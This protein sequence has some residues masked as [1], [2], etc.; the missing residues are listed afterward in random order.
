VSGPRSTCKRCGGPKP[1]GRG[2]QVCDACAASPPPPPNPN[3]H[4]CGGPKPPGRGRRLCAPCQLESEREIAPDPCL[5]CGGP[6]PPGSA[7]RLC[8]DCVELARWKKNAKKRS[9][10]QPCIDCGRPKG[11]GHRR[12]LCDPCRAKREREHGR[13]CIACGERKVRYPR[14]QLCT[15]CKL[16]SEERRRE[17][18][19]ERNRRYRAEG[20]FQGRGTKDLENHRMAARLR[21]ERDGEKLRL[22]PKDVYEER[23]GVGTHKGTLISTAPLRPFLVRALAEMEAE[24]G[25]PAAAA[26]AAK[27]GVSDKRIL[28]IANGREQV[29]ELVVD[30]LCT[31]LELPMSW[32]YDDE[33]A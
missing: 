2:R 7:R 11:P 8:D 33:A 5:N 27:S 14:A 6:K 23:Y 20:R 25:M 4:R 31:A 13:T 9:K 17:F 32:L 22:V 16:E 19:R 15:A 12:R 18:N 21:R 1:P 24:T 26:L 10:R 28:E 30:R 3:C 29:A